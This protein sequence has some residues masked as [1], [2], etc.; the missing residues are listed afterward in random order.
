MQVLKDGFLL[1]RE[2]GGYC[3]LRDRMDMQVIELFSGRSLLV[4]RGHGAV[5][6]QACHFPNLSDPPSSSLETSNFPRSISTIPSKFQVVARSSSVE[7]ELKLSTVL[8]SFKKVNNLCSITLNVPCEVEPMCDGES[9]DSDIE[10]ENSARD[11]L[12]LE[13]SAKDFLMNSYT[14]NLDTNQPSSFL[15]ET[16]SSVENGIL[17]LEEMDED[18]LSKRILKLS[19]VNKPKSALAIYNSMNFSGLKPDLHACNSL[20]SSLLRNGMLDNALKVFNSMKASELTTGHTHSL[21]LKAV[22][23]ARGCDTA[24]NMFGELIS[25]RSLREQI[26]ICGS[27]R[28]KI[29]LQV[30]YR[31]VRQKHSPDI[32]TLLSLMRVCIWGSLW[33]EAIEILKYS[34]PDGSLYNAA[35][36]GMC[37]IGNLD[38][39]KKLY[40]EMR[41]RGLQPDGR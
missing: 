36:Q 41:Q 10:K 24:I 11:V 8:F 6:M 27:R 33:N 19:T 35:I 26:D 22:A 38:L 13:L 23:D 28:P 25:S 7:L 34:E 29:A 9:E 37:L 39:C 31:M 16:K 40:T 32:F 12:R 1:I 5:F 20:I 14:E 3:L 15:D 21:I 4:D 17:Y 18:A 30:Y 2:L